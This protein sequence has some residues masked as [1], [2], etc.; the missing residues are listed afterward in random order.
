MEFTDKIK[1]WVTIDNRVRLLNEEIKEMRSTRN[2][3]AVNI[4]DLAEKNNLGNPTI[5]ITDGK[6]KFNDIKISSPLTFKFLKKCL[7]NCI[8]DENAVEKI[9]TYIKENREFRYTKDIRRTYTN[10][11]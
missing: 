1:Q 6:L 5:Q 10:N 9:M 11:T 4:M 2:E 8:S 7:Q 3:L